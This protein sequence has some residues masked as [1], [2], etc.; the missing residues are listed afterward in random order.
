M[1]TEDLDA[2]LTD[3]GVTVTSGSASGLGVLDMPDAIIGAGL[4]ISTSYSLL[5]KTSVFSSVKPFDSIT[6]DGTGYSIQTIR[7]IDD[8]VFT[9]LGLELP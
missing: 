3:F 2:F 8:G 5:V 7:K 4:E 1:I 6:V 9:R